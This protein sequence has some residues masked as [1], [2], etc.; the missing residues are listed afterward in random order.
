MPW[1][2]AFPPRIAPIAPTDELVGWPR[3]RKRSRRGSGGRVA[4]RISRARRDGAHAA[5]ITAWERR[6]RVR[7][8]TAPRLP[9]V[10]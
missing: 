3:R 9:P 8:R 10:V 4:D 1:L 2:P 6:C 7:R 5:M